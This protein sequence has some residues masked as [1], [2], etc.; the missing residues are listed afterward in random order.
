MLAFGFPIF[1]DLIFCQL[2]GARNP[3]ANQD[4]I[5]DTVWT[6]SLY[7]DITHTVILANCCQHYITLAS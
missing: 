3:L 1:D 2:Q 5:N 6:Y 7:I 4:Y